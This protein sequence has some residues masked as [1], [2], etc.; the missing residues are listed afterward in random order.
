MRGNANRRL[1]WPDGSIYRIIQTTEATGGQLLEMEWELPA[2]GWAP[3][4]HIHP[5]LTEEYE[6]LDGSLD[7]LIDG[8][9]RT[10]RPGE[11]IS[12]PPGA[13]HTFRPGG[14][15]VRVRNVHRPAL[16]F[17]PYI[18]SLCSAANERELGDLSGFK[19]LFVIAVL[20]REYPQHSRAPGRFLNLAVPALA[21]V[22]RL[23]GFKAG[24]APRERS[25]PAAFLAG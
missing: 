19:S 9:W 12:V 4:P 5:D 2:D 25:F 7:V 16:D 21:A 6:V 1:E 22:G 24:N 18:V 23:L 14:N 13:V 10:L 15:P 20:I 11:A 8:G 3:Q 17:E